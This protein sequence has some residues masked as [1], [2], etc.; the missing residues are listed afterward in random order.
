M[1]FI[2][3]R[4]YIYFINYHILFKISFEIPS[5]LMVKYLKYLLINCIPIQVGLF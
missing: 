3:E 2:I 1:L 4:V 5:K